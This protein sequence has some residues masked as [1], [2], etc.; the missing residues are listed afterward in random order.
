MTPPWAAGLDA[1][2]SQWREQLADLGFAD[3]GTRLRGRVTWTDQAG[4]QDT[5]RIEVQPG[6][7]FP[8]APPAVRVLNTGNGM[9]L[10]FHVDRPVQ[11]QPAGNLCLYDTDH[12]VEEAPWLDANCLVDRI[13][14]FLAKTSAGW[15]ADDVCDLERYLERELT[16]VLYDSDKIGNMVGPLRSKA[17]SGVVVVLPE[18]RRIDDA[19]SGQRH[20][21]DRGLV[22]KAD[23]GAVAS[24]LRTWD[25]VTRALGPGAGNVTRAIQMGAIEYLLLDYTRGSRSSTLALHVRGRATGQPALRSCDSAD[26]S[27]AAR[28][29]RA[30]DGAPDLADTKIAIVG[31]GAVGS[32]LADLLYRSGV[33]S[34]TLRDPETLRPGNVVRHLAG[35]ADVGL[36]KVRG[37]EKAL[38]RLALG[39]RRI[40]IEESRLTTLAEAVR[41]LHDHG[42]V[43][44]A[45]GNARATSLLAT[46]AR[47]TKRPVVS[48]CVQRNGEV[49]RVDRFPLRGDEVHLPA[50]PAVDTTG[51]PQERGCGSP[52]SLT[53]PG[54]VV[55]ASEL[56]SRVAIDEA[57]MTCS[58]PCT[59]ADVRVAQECSPFDRVGR[60]DAAARSIP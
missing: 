44:D 58:Y 11:G 42:V 3:D 2:V 35:D 20:R 34:L 24:P 18:R 32:F 22:W 21:K 43:V 23:I 37:V 31:L 57:R 16:L 59:V 45:T 26:T 5:A 52:V 8:F 28:T 4:A 14:D 41:L 55:A 9:E 17:E 6:D 54:A 49:L 51:L 50:L 60:V 13:R 10:T 27:V 40:D 25:D 7:D 56:A 39:D 29:L 1:Q 30:G 33:G 19:L 46:A 38:R 36:P 12:P 48:V 15:P 53:P 47:A